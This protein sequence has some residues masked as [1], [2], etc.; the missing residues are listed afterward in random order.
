M[1]N[2]RNAGLKPINKVFSDYPNCYF[3]LHEGL[4]GTDPGDIA[5]QAGTNLTCVPKT[6]TTAQWTTKPGWWSGIATNAADALHIRRAV[7]PAE[8]DSI[9]SLNGNVV[10]IMCRVFADTD[11]GASGR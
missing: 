7:S 11:P 2:S 9:F 4:A 6:T 8:Y 1:R 5:D 10:V 3:S